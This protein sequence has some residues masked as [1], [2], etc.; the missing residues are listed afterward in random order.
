M[1]YNYKEIASSARAFYEV[2]LLLI[3]ETDRWPIA[4]YS[5]PFLVNTAFSCELY[6]KAIITHSNPS[7]TQ[8]EF[9]ALG[10]RLDKLFQALPLQFQTEIKG[11][12]P[13]SRVK[14]QQIKEKEVYLGSLQKKSAFEER[15]MVNSHIKNL[16]STFDEMLAKNSNTFESWRYLFEAN[17]GTPISCDVWFLYAFCE[18]LHNVM[19]KI[20]NAQ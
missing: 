10:H 18:A 8:S 13:D 6:M 14:C 4:P 17:N 16:V 5:G 1:S 3:T 20:M 9:K 11:L 12:I 7:I 19:V 2:G 15:E